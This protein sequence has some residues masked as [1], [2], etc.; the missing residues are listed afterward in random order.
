MPRLRNKF[1]EYED[2]W[3]P[4]QSLEQPAAPAPLT[5]LV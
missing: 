5:A 1:S 2:K 4:T 3:W